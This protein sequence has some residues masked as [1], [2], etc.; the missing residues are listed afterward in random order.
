MSKKYRVLKC[1]SLF[2][3]GLVVII[4]CFGVWF[5]SLIP[6]A[7]VD[8]ASTTVADLPYISANEIPYRGKILAVV[9]STATMGS[10][11]KRT[12]Y[13]LTELSRA[14]YVFTANGFE[15]DI[16]S[17][18]GGKPPVVIDDEDIGA[19]DYAFLNDTTAQYKTSHTIKMEEV[20]AADY[21]AVF[22]AGG[23]GAMYDFPDNK[24]IQDLVKDVYQN[25]KVIGAVCHGPAALVNVR[26][27]NGNLLLKD[28]NVSGFTN[29]EELFLI[30]EAKSIFPF[31]LQDKMVAQGANFK[32]GPLYL[33]QVSQDK[34]LITGQNPWSTWSM[35]ESMIRQMGYTPKYR[36]ITDEEHAVRV[37]NVYASQGK[38]KAKELIE[39]LMLQQ[40]KSVDRLLIAK[41]SVISAMKGEVRQFFN[42]IGLVSFT[43]RFESKTN[44]I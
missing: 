42:L 20:I 38:Q 29:A 9:T 34:N 21:D 7:D 17:P 43:K 22:F 35:A 40:N 3:L 33:D 25:N 14:Y 24:A 12:G 36:A 19:Y 15:V 23:K 26:L 37:L 28:K 1:I 2:M 27:D 16:A 13:E 44:E 11:G 41:H 8:L 5:K 18:E 4:V 10:S 6:P 32:E 39:A 31:L 30:K